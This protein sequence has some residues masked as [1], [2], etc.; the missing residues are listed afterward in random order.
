MNKKANDYNRKHDYN[1]KKHKDAKIE[2]I[3]IYE[4]ADGKMVYEKLRFEGKHFRFRH[5]DKDGKYVYNLEGITPL[6]YLLPK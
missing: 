3:Y 2:K 6:P 4:D 5:K 1:P